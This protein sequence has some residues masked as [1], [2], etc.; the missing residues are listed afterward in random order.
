MYCKIGMNSL[1]LEMLNS[2]GGNTQME[3]NHHISLKA[4]QVPL[5]LKCHPIFQPTHPKK[6]HV[7]NLTEWYGVDNNMYAHTHCT[8]SYVCACVNLCRHRPWIVT[9]WYSTLKLNPAAVRFWG[10]TVW[11][12]TSWIWHMQA[13]NYDVRKRRH[14]KWYMYSSHELFLKFCLGNAFHHYH[15]H[16]YSL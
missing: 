8:W 16:T 1:L 9:A 15:L 10:N 3:C 4:C 14:Q 11:H 2:Y 6:R 5:L 7:W 12:H 13:Y